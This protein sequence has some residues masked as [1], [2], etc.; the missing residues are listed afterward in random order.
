LSLHIPIHK[1]FN[2][3]GKFIFDDGVEYDVTFQVYLLEAGNTQGSVIF[4]RYDSELEYRFNNGVKFR[5]EG[6][7][8]GLRIVSEGC[9][10]FALENGALIYFDIPTRGARFYLGKTK[11]FDQEKIFK[12]E[13]SLCNLNFELGITNL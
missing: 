1:E 5:F 6:N 2:G 13:K 11:I 12:N 3:K 8:E 9:V 7:S 4:N 10:M